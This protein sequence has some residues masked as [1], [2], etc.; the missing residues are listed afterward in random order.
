MRAWEGDIHNTGATAGG[1]DSGARC[2]AAQ[3][4]VME[5]VVIQSTDGAAGRRRQTKM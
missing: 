4:V 5:S 3:V 1:I 2:G